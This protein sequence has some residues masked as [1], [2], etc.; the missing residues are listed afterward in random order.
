M[1][2]TETIEYLFTRL[3]MFQRTGAAAYKSNL[4][5]TIYLDKLLNHPHKNYPTIH[6]AGTNGKGS[7]SHLIASVLQESGYKTGLYT[8]PHLLDFR[9]RIKI[10]GI[11]VSEEFVIKFTEKLKETIELIEPSFFE[12]TV[13]MAFQYFAENKADV[14]VIETGLG[15]R[16]DSTNIIRPE[17]A[18]IT[19][20]TLEHTALLGNTIEKIANEK[21]GIIKA[22]VPVVIGRKTN[23]TDHVFLQRAWQNNAE[24]FFAPD[25]FDCRFKG[26]DHKYS[27]FD[28]FSN[29]EML[30]PELF[31]DLSGS[32]QSENIATALQAISILQKS[33]T[34]VDFSNISKGIKNVSKN[35]ALHGRWEIIQEKPMLVLDIAHNPDAVKNMLRQLENHQ[36]N[37]LHIVLGM[38]ND[39]NHKG[40]L[41]LFPNYATYYFCKP[42]VPRGLDASELTLMAKTFKLNGNN[43]ISVDYAISEALKNANESDLILVTGSAFVVAEGLKKI[44]L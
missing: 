10:N 27:V 23:E 21:A 29:G 36:F 28:V 44:F 15:G 17:L 26:N 6:V 39:K 34:K 12:I 22:E 31:C 5:N 2:Y 24:I 42:D 40:V 25:Y 19:N 20:V 18:V 32:Y 41:S 9:E 33:F 8:S 37:K 13:A 4:D 7:V 43:C 3:P 30:Y 11:S 35:T 1:N 14:A 16:L 38:S